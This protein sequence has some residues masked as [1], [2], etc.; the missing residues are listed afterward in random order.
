MGRSNHSAP[1]EKG[2]A[3]PGEATA[4][5]AAAAAVSRKSLRVIVLI[6]SPPL[7]LKLVTQ[8]KLHDTRIACRG[9]LGKGGRGIVEVGVRLTEI[10]VVQGV[11]EFRAEL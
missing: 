7:F 3:P 2:A 4:K 1:E 8:R 6:F 9:D 10:R 5:A 11:E